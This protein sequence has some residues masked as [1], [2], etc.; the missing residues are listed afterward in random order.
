MPGTDRITQRAQEEYQ[1]V[2]Q[3]ILRLR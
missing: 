1:K 3:R 2:V